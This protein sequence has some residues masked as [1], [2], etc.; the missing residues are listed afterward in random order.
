[1]ITQ[2][3]TGAPYRW[4]AAGG[5]VL[6]NGVVNVTT[7]AAIAIADSDQLNLL[8]DMGST[9]ACSVVLQWSH[10]ATS[11]YSEMVEGLGSL[12]GNLQYYNLYTKVWTL[13]ASGGTP[14]ALSF[15]RP[16]AAHFVRVGMWANAA[17]LITDYVQCT[18]ERARLGQLGAVGA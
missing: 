4:G 6:G 1:M 17:P 3:L 2:F 8:V 16:T 15:A 7:C 11:W 13:V 10:D 9:V 14:Y 12:V 5:N 18:F